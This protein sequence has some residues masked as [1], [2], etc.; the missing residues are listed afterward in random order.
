MSCAI[1][2]KM[3]SELESNVLL[4]LNGWNIQEYTKTTINIVLYASRH[5]KERRHFS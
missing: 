2:S 4:F 1:I 3:F 5:E